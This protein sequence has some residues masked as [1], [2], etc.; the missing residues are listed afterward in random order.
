VL[1]Y[2]AETVGG[3]QWDLVYGI[4]LVIV[5]AHL[6]VEDA[7]AAALHVGAQFR[8]KQ[9]MRR[10]VVPW[11]AG[12]DW[13]RNARRVPSEWTASDPWSLGQCRRVQVGARRRCRP[14]YG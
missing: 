14:S 9:Q 6:S 7:M 10:A 8:I 12:V 13:S 3:S 4:P 1:P 11:A 5:T 2:N